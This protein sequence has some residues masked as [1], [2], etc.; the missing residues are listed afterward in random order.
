MEAV[1]FVGIV[2]LFGIV[3]YAL[4]GMDKPHTNKKEYLR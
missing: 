3:F 4:K 1:A 2:I